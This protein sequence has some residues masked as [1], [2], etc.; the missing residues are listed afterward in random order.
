MG[1]AKNIFTAG[2]KKIR[3]PH[4]TDLAGHVNDMLNAIDG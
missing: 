2:R 3:E 1:N 4:V